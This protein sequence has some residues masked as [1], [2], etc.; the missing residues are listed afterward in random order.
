M[1]FCLFVFSGMT[2][3]SIATWPRQCQNTHRRS[4]TCSRRRKPSYGT[5]KCQ[6]LLKIGSMLISM[7]ALNSRA[8]CFWFP[9]ILG[10]GSFLCECFLAVFFLPVLHVYLILYEF[11]VG[12]QFLTYNCKI[13]LMILSLDFK[14][15]IVSYTFYL[16]FCPQ[17]YCIIFQIVLL[18]GK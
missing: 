5:R 8:S 16:R 13:S 9:I 10:V 15:I 11:A 14:G 12:K 6:T 3:R 17:N 2:G 18:L 4:R 7:A 1:L